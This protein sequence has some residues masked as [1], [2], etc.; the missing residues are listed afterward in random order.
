MHMRKQEDLLQSVTDAELTDRLS[1]VMDLERHTQIF[2]FLRRQLFPS[3][4]Q[5]SRGSCSFAGPDH[6]FVEVRYKDEND[7]DFV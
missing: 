1:S 2:E 3:L 7:L 5:D 4:M 6:D